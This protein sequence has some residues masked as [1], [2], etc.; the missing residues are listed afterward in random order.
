MNKRLITKKYYFSVDGETEVLYFKWLM[1]IINEQPN[2]TSKV[3]FDDKKVQPTSWAKRLTITE[4][5]IIKRI[6]DIESND[7]YNINYA[8]N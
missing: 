7:N 1:K 2:I 3:S 8:N 6:C 4:P 5:I